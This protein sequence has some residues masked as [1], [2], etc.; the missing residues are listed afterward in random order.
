MDYFP[1]LVLSL[2]LKC[3]EG[4]FVMMCHM[5]GVSILL[6]Q[7]TSAEEMRLEALTQHDSLILILMTLLEPVKP[8]C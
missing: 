5:S 1:V 2:C 4:I 6:D 8:T 3:S 7:R